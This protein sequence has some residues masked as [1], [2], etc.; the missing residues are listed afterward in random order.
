MSQRFCK[1]QRSSAPLHSF[2]ARRQDRNMLLQMHYTDY[3]MEDRKL[4][5]CKRCADPTSSH[6]TQNVWNQQSGETTTPVRTPRARSMHLSDDVDVVQG[7]VGLKS[8]GTCEGN[9]LPVTS[10]RRWAMYAGDGPH[11]RCPR[12]FP[13]SLPPSA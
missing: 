12:R 7:S 4:C 5:G 13:D 8:I 9:Q 6:R 1:I 2:S 3:T 11:S 10:L